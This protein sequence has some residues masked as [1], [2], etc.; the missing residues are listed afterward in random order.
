MINQVNF[1]GKDQLEFFLFI[2]IK[3]RQIDESE[4]TGKERDQNMTPQILIEEYDELDEQYVVEEE[5]AYHSTAD[6]D[7]LE[8]DLNQ[9]LKT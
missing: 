8:A 4:I 2:D 3:V 9:E 6:G 5:L 7:H 1:I